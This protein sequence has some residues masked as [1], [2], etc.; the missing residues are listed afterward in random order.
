MKYRKAIFVVTYTV[1]KGK[2]YYLILKRKLHWKGWEFPKGGLETLKERL[3]IKKAVKREVVE[4]TGLIPT[5]ITRHNF[6]GKFKY[7]KPLKDRPG[8]IGQTY[9]LFSAKVKKKKPILKKNQDAEHSGYLWADYKKAMKKLTWPNQRKCL[10][11]VNSWLKHK[12]KKQ[13]EI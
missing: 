9:K 10:R 5:K 4:E 6:S 11:I 8:L 2:V 7:E 13:N 3:F 1:D 12:V